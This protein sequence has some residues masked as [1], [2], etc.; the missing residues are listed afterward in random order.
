M[1]VRL[2]YL[3]IIMDKRTR[4]IVIA[5]SATIFLAPVT[6]LIL[7]V[8]LMSIITPESVYVPIS[9]ILGFFVGVLAYGLHLLKKPVVRRGFLSNFRARFYAVALVTFVG[10]VLI[11]YQTPLIFSQTEL[12]I[13]TWLC[14]KEAQLVIATLKI[15]KVHKCDV[16]KVAYKN[17][18]A[19]EVSIVHGPASL[20]N[21]GC[22]YNMS[23]AILID[24]KIVS[25]FPQK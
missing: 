21:L 5:L 25:G 2:M 17:K 8:L 3:N 9:L 14:P 15:E 6:G 4:D 12:Y 20:C 19:S 24:G 10:I 22:V 1:P 23:Q 11:H 13:P 16:R 7:A 18:T